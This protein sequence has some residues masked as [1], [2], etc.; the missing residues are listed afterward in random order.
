MLKKCNVNADIVHRSAPS[1]NNY[2]YEIQS[3]ENKHSL[4]ILINVNKEVLAVGLS[5]A[6]V[7]SS[8]HSSAAC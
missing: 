1:Y 6:D 8:I 3:G 2:S 5:S 4:I 7:Q